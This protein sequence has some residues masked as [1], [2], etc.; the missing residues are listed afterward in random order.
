MA[1]QPAIAPRAK[2]KKRRIGRPPNHLGDETRQRILLAAREF[3]TRVGFERATNKEIAAH[4]DVTAGALYRYFDS[5]GELW[6]AV[7]NAA[8]AEIV[9]RMRRAVETQTSVRATL[10]ALITAFTG[11]NDS[12]RIATRFLST[13]PDE[14]Q[15]HPELKRRVLRDPGEVFVIVNRVV[16]IAIERGEVAPD[17]AQLVVSLAIAMMMGLSAYANTLGATYG[18]YAANAF[19]ELLEGRLF[20]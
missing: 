5:K 12:E 15:R 17:K 6:G 18:E 19:I 8:N 11:T 4:A 1:K 2:P 10:R 13:V 14:M 9:P 16:E 7:L 20:R 3:F